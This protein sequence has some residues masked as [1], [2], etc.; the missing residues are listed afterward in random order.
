M[1]KLYVFLGFGIVL[2]GLLGFLIAKFWLVSAALAGGFLVYFLVDRML[3]VLKRR[4][5]T[6]WPAYV[7]VTLFFLIL[8]LAFTLFVSIPLIEQVRSFADQITPIFSTFN[9]QLKQDQIPLL[10]K[11]YAALKENVVASQKLIVSI[12]GS[13]VAA[14]FAILLVS[15]TLLASRATLKQTMLNSIPNDYFE[16]SVGIAQ[17]IREH[18]QSYV[19][20][21]TLETIVMIVM[22]SIG[23]WA[24]GLP[25]PWL[26]GIV[27]GLFN[28]IP[29]LGVVFTVIPVGLVAFAAGGYSLLGWS[30][31]VL[32]IGRVIDELLLQPWLVSKFVDIHPFMVVVITLIAG[33]V[34]GA[35]GMVIAIPAYV[36]AKIVLGGLYE[37]LKSVQRH[38]RILQEEKDYQKYHAGQKQ[39]QVKA[40]VL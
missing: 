13:V 2:L 29:Y 7:M 40:H 6:G 34:F 32:L 4:R 3:D 24:V 26:F 17:R 10:A 28:I 18:V 8:I 37:Y 14:T 30:M 35:V 21:R 33:E 19:W 15:I 5:I 1:N 38:E 12:S 20:A 16:V 11:G 39:H 22:H 25:S 27:A 31:G 23:F 9:E 36:I